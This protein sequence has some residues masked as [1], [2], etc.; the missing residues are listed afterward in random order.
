M[1]QLL[2]KRFVYQNDRGYTLAEAL[3]ALTV[4]M[5]CAA[6][7][8]LMYDATYRILDA[9]KSEKNTEWE[10]FIIQLRNELQ[11]SSN[12]NVMDGKLN[13]ELE[14]STT[15]ISQYED[16]LRRQINGQGHEVMLQNV[17][18]AAFALK[19]GKLYIHVT[20]QDGEE[21]G[22]SLYPFNQTSS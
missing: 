3:I 13:Y 10:I 22:T 18:K 21:E 14:G 20:F 8:P 15:S 4:F 1:Y 16:K 6:S 19:G 2:I 5:T 7:F 11:K 12:W 17:K 9:S